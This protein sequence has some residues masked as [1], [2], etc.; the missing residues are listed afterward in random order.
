MFDFSVPARI[1]PVVTI[2]TVAQAV[3]LARALLAGGLSVLEVTLRTD[4]ALDAIR[5]I[6]EEVD[7]VVIGA[8]TVLT[9]R[10]RDQA[11]L[12]GAGFAVSPGLTDQLLERHD[13]PILP[14]IATASEL[15]R[16]IE[17]GLSRFKFFPAIP[18][19]GAAVLAAWNGPFPD[20]LFCPTGG[21]DAI[22]AAGLLSLPN[23]FCVGGGWMVPRDLIAAGDWSAITRLAAEAAAI[24]AR[25]TGA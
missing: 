2:E 24:G 19:G 7:G 11:F 9:S 10:A 21:V 17:A 20:A 15:M 8:G 1:M 4:V 13:L 14:G 22:S 18:M 3:P 12:A 16:G 25:S 6:A 5:S 23:V